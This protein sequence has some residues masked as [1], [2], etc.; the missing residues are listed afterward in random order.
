MIDP[1][2]IDPMV[3][4]RKQAR[5]L[6]RRCLLDLPDD[7][8]LDILA[9]TNDVRSVATMMCVNSYFSHSCI[10]PVYEIMYR[11]ITGKQTF[12]LQSCTNKMAHKLRALN[13]FFLNHVPK[14][15]EE[16]SFEC[17]TFCFLR[18]QQFT[19]FE[20]GRCASLKILNDD[21]ISRKHLLIILQEEVDDFALAHC[22][23]L[24]VNGI[25]LS[26]RVYPNRFFHLQKGAEFHIHPGDVLT[27]GHSHV[28]YR[29]DYM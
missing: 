3:Q 11:R 15:H 27:M 17:P 24:G 16:I 23:V 22:K 29:A 1:T 20:L 2:S 21:T 7:V 14:P 18:S 4:T 9:S 28:Q 19:R 12:I 6:R 8:I 5:L 26:K 25:N 10:K 13:G